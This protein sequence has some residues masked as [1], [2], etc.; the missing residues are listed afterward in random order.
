MGSLGKIEGCM[1]YVFFVVMFFV[2]VVLF[3]FFD[4]ILILEI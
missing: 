3:S 4:F 2:D 1:I